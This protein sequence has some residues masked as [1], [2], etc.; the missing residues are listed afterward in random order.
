MDYGLGIGYN[1]ETNSTPSHAA[2][3]GSAAVSS[4]RTG[5]VGQFKSNFVA[6]SSN[7][8]SS[9]AYA[10]KGRALPGFI[11]GGSIGGDINRTR[12][13]TSL[14]GFVSGGS[15]SGDANR[16]GTTTSLPGFVSGGSITGDVNRTQTIGQNT[17]GNHSRHM[18]RLCFSVQLSFPFPFYL[19]SISMLTKFICSFWFC[20][21]KDRGRGRRR[22]SGWDH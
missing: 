5:M 12:T 9:S 2:P 19:I 18:E 20:S 7:S 6:A 21:S 15:I 22:P 8:Q 10:N 3:S 11:S 14:P 16:T 1:P 4:S 13:T 17:G